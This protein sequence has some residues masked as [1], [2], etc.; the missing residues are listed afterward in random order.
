MQTE[1]V[2]ARDLDAADESAQIQ[3]APDPPD[4]GGQRRAEEAGRK[5][6]GWVAPPS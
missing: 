2:E 3:T 5:A 4:D 6:P 1:S